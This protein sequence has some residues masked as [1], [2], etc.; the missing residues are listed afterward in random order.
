[1]TDAELRQ[2][3][4]ADAPLYDKAR[5]SYPGELFVDLAALTG[6]GPGSTVIE[7]GPGTG[8]A[9]RDLVRTGATVTAVELGPALAGRL[10]ANLPQV[11]VVRAA[12]E[13]WA[14]PAP[15]ALVAGFTAWHWVDRTVRAERAHAALRV[16]G[17]LATVT[18][19]HVRGGTIDFFVRAQESYLRWDPAT[20]PD[21]PFLAADEVPPAVDEIDTSPLFEPVTRLRYRQ[22]IS[23]TADSYLDV[24]RTYSGHR[25]LPAAAREGLLGE[26]RRSID[27]DHAGM[28][29]KSYLHELRIAR[30]TGC[31]T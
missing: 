16:G 7:I 20:D 28:I 18:T 25:A 4:D 27:H 11:H 1:M 23:Y 26:L 17:H 22:D 21:E 30:R 10:A 15:V 8:Q 29:T 12:F 9:T 24:L 6:L 5:P 2:I 19:E 31:L 14:P 3:F 13:D